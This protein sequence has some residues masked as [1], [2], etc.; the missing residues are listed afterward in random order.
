MI[1]Q[2]I[3][4]SV[5]FNT[6]TYFHKKVFSMASIRT[7]NIGDTITTKKISQIYGSNKLK[8]LTKF[9]THPRFIYPMTIN[10][11]HILQPG[12]TLEV[13]AKGKASTKYSESYVTVSH[14]NIMF[15]IFS[16]EL[17]NL[18]I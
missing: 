8:F 11:Q 15:D 7:T 16:S 4:C 14:N 10:P 6:S 1:L 3:C 5:F 9:S 13:V 12:T 2:N 18:F 17:R